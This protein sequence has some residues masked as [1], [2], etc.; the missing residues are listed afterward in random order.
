MKHALHKSQI[1]EAKT[2][3]IKYL[4]DP[5]FDTKWHFHSEY[6][7]FVVLESSGTRFIGDNISHFQEGDLVFTGPNLPHLWRNDEIYFDKANPLRVQGIVIYIPENFLGEGSLKK[8]EMLLIRQLFEKAARGIQIHGGTAA[9]LTQM[10]QE[11]L[12]LKGIESI[13]QLLSIL[14]VLAEAEEIE[15]ISSIG[16]Y[17]TSKET[18]KDKMSGVYNYILQNFKRN[19]MLEEVAALANMSP[20][21]FSRYFKAR[22]NKPFSVFISELRIGLACKL[23]M[24][25]E[26][27]ISQICYKCGFNTLSNFNKQ[28]RNL[29][30]KTPFE[31]RKEYAKIS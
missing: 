18:D 17:N 1:P 20:T 27:S 8:E 4:N 7:L 9:R 21:T 13:I 24:E 6:Q 15:F 31:Y 28:F 12:A 26:E 22:T 3:V 2:F 29:M 16:Y 10:M 5:C 19:I 23:L 30:H 11:L 14:Q 25:E